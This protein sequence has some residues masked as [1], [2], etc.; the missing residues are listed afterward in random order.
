MPNSDSFEQYKATYQKIYSKEGEESYRRIIFL[1][2]LVKIAEHNTN[3]S[4]TYQMGVN[5]FTDLTN[6]EFQAIYLSSLILPN[7]PTDIKV[8]QKETPS[9]INIDWQ[10]LGKVS[11]IK[12]QGSCLSDW[13]FA[14]VAAL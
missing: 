10:A 14:A 4:N 1:K 7:S 9:N 5:Q 6:E 12:N 3:P 11:P 13:A 8:L 2:N